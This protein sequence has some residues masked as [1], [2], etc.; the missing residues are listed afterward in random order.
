M[1]GT[2]TVSPLK[3]RW[4]RPSTPF[5]AAISSLRTLY[6]GGGWLP[7]RSRNAWLTSSDCPLAS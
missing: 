3:A 1:V 4:M 7:K 5:F 2:L 6:S